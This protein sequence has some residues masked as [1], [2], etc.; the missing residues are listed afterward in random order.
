MNLGIRNL[1]IVKKCLEVWCSLENCIKQRYILYILSVM[2]IC[3][4]N[5][6]Y[7]NLL[8]DSNFF[9]SLLHTYYTII[10]PKSSW[11]S[12]LFYLIT[13]MSQSFRSRTFSNTNECIVSSRVYSVIT[14][15]IL[16][17]KDFPKTFRYSWWDFCISNCFTIFIF[18]NL[19][20][21]LSKYK[22]IVKWWKLTNTGD[23]RVWD[24]EGMFYWFCRWFSSK[25]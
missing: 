19:Q 8:R 2:L 5:S 23:Q 13:L 20:S 25:I 15:L 14:N 9:P 12:K 16:L 6:R 18:K 21:I 24:I 10:W 17:S 4:V 22:L 7:L 1:Q 11:C 3:T